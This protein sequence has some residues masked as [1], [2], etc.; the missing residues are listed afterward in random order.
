M[1][2]PIISLS[3]IASLLLSC[4]AGTDNKSTYS[5]NG[6]SFDMTQ[7]DV[8]EQGFVCNP[9]EEQNS[10]IRA[11]CKHM[12]LT[13]IAF[14]YPTKDYSLIIGSTGKVDKIG[15]EFSENISMDA[16]FKLHREITFFFPNKYEKGTFHSQGTARRDEWRDKNNTSAVLLLFDGIPPVTKTSLSITFWSP[17]HIEM[18]NKKREF[19]TEKANLKEDGSKGEKSVTTKPI[20]EENNDDSNS[21]KSSEMIANANLLAPTNLTDILS[22]NSSKGCLPPID[23]KPIN[24][25]VKKRKFLEDE[26][27]LSSVVVEEVDGQRYTINVDYEYLASVSRWGATEVSQALTLNRKVSIRSVGCGAAGQWIIAREIQAY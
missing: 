25:V 2:I 26:T 4:S 16:Y 24:G 27:T 1:K 6:I 9:P 13:G 7:K 3:L 14:G 8:E 23:D 21:V 18:S 22:E 17:R 15:A 19:T 10:D 12:D 11:N 5:H 20:L